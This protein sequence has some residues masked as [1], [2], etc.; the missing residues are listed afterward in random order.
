[1]IT[2]CGCLPRPCLSFHALL[3]ACCVL[4]LSE[5]SAPQTIRAPEIHGALKIL[6]CSVCANKCLLKELVTMERL[7]VSTHF[8]NFFK[9]NIFNNG[10]LRNIL[11]I[12]ILLVAVLP[13]YNFLVVYPSFSEF[14]S[15]NANDAAVRVARHFVSMFGL[16]KTVLN[17][18]TIRYDE[19]ADINNMRSELRLIKIKLISN[20]GEVLFSSDPEDIGTIHNQRYFHDIVAK[21][22]VV[23]MDI[24]KETESLEGELMSVDVIETYVPLM[25]GGD[26]LGA[27]EIYYD[28]TAGKQQLNK[29]L[30]RSSVVVFAVTLGLLTAIM[31]T[32]FVLT[33]TISKRK[34]VEKEREQLIAELQDK[35]A[36]IKK[37]SGM[38]PICANCKK[39]RDD[40]G[41]WKQIESYILAHSEAEFSHGICPECAQKLY[42][43]LL[44]IDSKPDQ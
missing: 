17:K 24:A 23:A 13:V 38:L 21:G 2:H 11:L 42:P 15:E 25:K 28:I 35:V 36:K 6:K 39:I 30:T 19:W 20:S 31:A 8:R 37:L 10:Y 12:S 3:E 32:L 29:L 18:D 5:P 40:K 33:K 14:L 9:S 41:Y 43:D 34:R 26:F 7:I 4:Y 27:F 44:D 22:N 16:T 1:M